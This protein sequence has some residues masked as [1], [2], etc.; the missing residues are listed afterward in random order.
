MADGVGR[1]HLPLGLPGRYA[2][3]AVTLFPVAK[4]AEV[5]ALPTERVALADLRPHPRNYRKH[6]ADQLA[7]I[8]AS[9]T[10]HG[11]YRNVVVATDG[12]ILAGHGVAQ[13]A[14]ELGWTEVDVVRLDVEA[15]SPAALKVLTGDNEMGRL[16]EIDD[17]LLT[18]HLRAL[19]E[20]DTLL[21]TGFDDQM[22]A[23]LVMVTRPAEE[24]LGLD[25]AA[26][27]AGAGMP[28]FET[29]SRTA[30]ALVL[31]FETTAAR[32]ELIEKI[33]IVVAKKLRQTWS[34]QW[35]PQEKADLRSLKFDDVDV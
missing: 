26:H 19:A 21:G 13:A 6:P 22:L 31:H 8:K 23:N 28:E 2:D 3:S 16:A 25:E 11:Q 7:H 12:T 24:I 15:D 30:A 35:P 27:W 14:V 33:G 18:E 5:V 17:R 1:R 10:E 20:L 34:A 4:V 29:G 9:L 32:D